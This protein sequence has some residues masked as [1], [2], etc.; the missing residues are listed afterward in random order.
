MSGKLIYPYG[1]LEN[2]ILEA[3]SFVDEASGVALQNIELPQSDLGPRRYGLVD[4]VPI[5]ELLSFQVEF[6]LDESLVGEVLPDP[7]T[8]DD[9]TRAVVSVACSATKF[10]QGHVLKKVGVGK[11]TGELRVCRSDVR[12]L[13]TVIPSLVRT[14]ACPKQEG[15]AEFVGAVLAEGPGAELALDKSAPSPQGQFKYRYEKF[16]SSE[17]VDWLKQRPDDVFYVDPRSTPTVY[18][19]LRWISLQTVLTNKAVTG[20]NA[21]LRRA[22]GAVIGQ[23][24][25]T[26]LLV[27]SVGSIVE[28]EDQ[29]VHVAGEPWRTDLAAKVGLALFPDEDP[30]ERLRKLHS[31]FRDPAEIPV[32]VSKIGSIAHDL[33]N[34]G[35]LLDQAARYMDNAQMSG[36]VP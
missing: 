21:A 31:Q 3:R 35:K 29:T 9:D 6:K 12:G 11:W 16:A 25:W 24:V 22:F 30:D 4:A 10:R 2:V 13:V 33:T 27:I 7:T 28:G 19:N 20:V 17:N 5:W 1:R 15:F 26:Q 18:L 36:S 14:K 34:T 32:L 8:L 23:D